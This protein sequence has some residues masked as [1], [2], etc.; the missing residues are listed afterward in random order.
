MRLS[1]CSGNYSVTFYAA[2]HIFE[3]I[4]IV[5]GRHQNSNNFNVKSML[6]VCILTGSGEELRPNEARALHKFVIGA[7]GPLIFVKQC[8]AAVE[9]R[10]NFPVKHCG[11]TTSI[12]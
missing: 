6:V 4:I 8:R 9:Q 12:V 5:E 7:A 1:E 2:G 11:W 3:P 10:N